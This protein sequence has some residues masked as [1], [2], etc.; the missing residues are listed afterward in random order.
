ML[1]VP[2]QPASCISLTS[3]PTITHRTASEQHAG[4]DQQPLV[5]QVLVQ[6]ERDHADGGREQEAEHDALEHD[7]RAERDPQPLEEDHDLEALAVDRGEPEQ[8]EPEQHRPPPVVA[9]EQAPAALVVVRD[10]AGP[11]HRGGRTSS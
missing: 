10:P 3:S 2:I 1:V 7:A 6:D 11:V 9:S 8:P 4:D 5:R